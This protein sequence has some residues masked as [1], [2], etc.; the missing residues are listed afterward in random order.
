MRDHE[1]I[2]TK[3]DLAKAETYRRQRLA[4]LVEPKEPM[5]KCIAIGC[6]KMHNRS[7]PQCAECYR[8]MKQLELAMK[9]FL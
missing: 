2:M 9:F 1:P 3:E 6:G 7:T 4:R 8:E 5:K